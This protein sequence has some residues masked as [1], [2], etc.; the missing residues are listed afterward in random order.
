[1]AQL[2]EDFWKQEA[3]AQKAEVAADNPAS[4]NDTF[5]DRI[6][7]FLNVAS[8]KAETLDLPAYSRERETLQEANELLDTINTWFEMHDIY[9]ASTP[10]E[11][12]LKE[13]GCPVTYNLHLLSFELVRDTIGHLGIIAVKRGN[14]SQAMDLAVQA[15]ELLEIENIV[16]SQVPEQYKTLQPITFGQIHS[17]ISRSLPEEYWCPT[18]ANTD[19]SANRLAVLAKRLSRM[20]KIDTEVYPI[21]RW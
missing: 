15:S 9:R 17:A 18:F 2:T 4:N 20:L 19:E 10:I 12:Q 8:E 14:L 3:E 13:S 21:N 5:W 7:T 11:Q 16:R 1:V 6:E